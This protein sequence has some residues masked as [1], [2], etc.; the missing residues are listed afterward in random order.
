M[1]GLNAT[2]RASY[3][4]IGART[5]RVKLSQPVTV[6]DSKGGRSKTWVEYGKAWGSVSELPFAKN[7]AEAAMIR[8]VEIPYRDDVAVGHR[9]EV[10]SLVLK[11]ILLGNP[12][13]R[14]KALQMHCAEEN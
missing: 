12:E 11:V 8:V 14:N 3:R 13:L 1:P 2:A 5:K 10:G 6:T 7:E 9:V 4:P